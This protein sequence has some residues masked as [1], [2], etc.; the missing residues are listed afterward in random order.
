MLVFFSSKGSEDVLNDIINIDLHIHSAASEYKEAKGYLKNST[1]DNI[2]VLLKKLNDNNINLFSITDHNRFDLEL[3]KKAKVLIEKGMYKNILNILP[4]IEFDVQIEEE[5]EA[6]H[7][8]CIFDDFKLDKLTDINAVLNQKLLTKPT[9]YYTKDE[10]ETILKKINL[11]TLL[12]AHQHKHFDNASGGKRS[13]SNS[14]D[15][16]YEFIKTGYINALEYQRPNVQGM[17]INSLKK[18][19]KNV[20]S[21]IGS[22]CHQWEYY[23]QKDSKNGY[24]G[25]VSKI[26]ALPT[27][28]GLVFSFTSMDTRFNR[29]KNSNANYIE[30]IKIKDKEYYLS[31]GINAIIGDN[32]SGKTML[33]DILT[34]SK[35]KNEYKAIKKQNEIEVY[36]LGKPTK[37]YIKQNQIIDDVR[38]GKLFST[39]KG[40]KYKDIATKQTFKTR[41]NNYATKL[42]KSINKNIEVEELKNNLENIMFTPVSELYEI[43]IPN[44]KN[45]LLVV[46]NEFEERVESLQSIYDEL[47]DEY[48]DNKRFYNKNKGLNTIIT[49]LRKL[50][51]EY[52][53]KSIKIN[54][55]ILI[56]NS[57]INRCETFNGNMSSNET[58]KE[59]EFKEYKR[60]K[61]KFIKAITSLIKLQNKEIAFPEFPKPIKGISKKINNGYS[62]NKV[63]GY[64]DINEKDNFYME[65]FTKGYDEEEIKKISSKEELVTALNGISKYEDINNWYKKV[66][67][68]I[69]G[70][71]S[72]E[73][74]IEKVST[75]ESMGKTPGEIAI[76]FYDFELKHND[77]EKNVIL[78]DQPED[79]ISNK[80]ISDELIKYINENRD[81]KQIII[82]T[83]NPVLVV[84]LDVDNV[85]LLNKD[86]KNNLEVK[87]GCLEFTCESYSMI[88][89]VANNMD[90]GIEVV[91]K[92]FKLYEN[93]NKS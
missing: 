75:K 91:E 50:L 31:N 18:I 14:V 60:D 80:I 1:I 44:I 29:L 47:I 79:D 30:K 3:Y 83:H 68:F 58:D 17:I 93:K 82:V 70:C 26:R 15:N 62:F 61:Q 8:I 69:D 21:I 84:N 63:T 25:Y 64:N 6:C 35:L 81:K 89:E 33:L 92:R 20:A 22:D 5:K 88:D 23:P 85:I 28:D 74:Y 59:K 41:I 45:D 56:K 36:E 40:N 86:Y 78:I 73:T 76:V 4:G 49:E 66:N 87:N 38:S 48:N 65:L 16:I 46:E 11:S 43:A 34:D 72:E 51:V 52:T 13:L 53:K 10:F 57:I 9:D 42:I 55:E 7:I 37:E 90:G 39:S 12:I 19:N 77:E 32:G 27:F 24:K 71:T 67:S 2:D 54:K